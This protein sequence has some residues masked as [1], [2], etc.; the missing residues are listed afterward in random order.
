MVGQPNKFEPGGE[1][2]QDQPEDFIFPGSNERG[3]YP[4]Q[5]GIEA[6]EV[7]PEEDDVPGLDHSGRIL[8]V[9]GGVYGEEGPAPQSEIK[10]VQRTSTADSD[11]T[12]DLVDA[13]G[14]LDLSNSGECGVVIRVL[15]S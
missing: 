13:I 6:V 7:L 15:N 11:N 14:D 5:L 10:F 8:G 2:D 4:D 3:A 1:S 12:E 9:P